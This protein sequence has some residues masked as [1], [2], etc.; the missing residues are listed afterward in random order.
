MHYLVYSSVT[1]IT[2]TSRDRN[3]ENA[4]KSHHWIALSLFL[5]SLQSESRKMSL[6]IRPQRQNMSGAGCSHDCNTCSI[7]LRACSLS[8]GLFLLQTFRFI[9]EGTAGFM[10]ET[11]LQVVEGV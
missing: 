4:L 10:L 9:H 5:V 11:A 8:P 2:T 6:Y 7:T 3:T 1:R